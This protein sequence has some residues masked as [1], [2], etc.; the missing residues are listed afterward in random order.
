MEHYDAIVLGTGGIGSAAL[1]HLARSGARVLGIDRFHPPHDRGSS[2]GQTRVIRQAYFEHPDYVPLLLESYR[3]WRE[4]EQLSEQKLFHQIGL[5]QIGPA[6]G[7]VIPG[8]LRAAAAHDLPVCPITAD[9]IT[10]RWPGLRIP[11][12]LV[13]AFEPAAGYLLV[14]DCVQ[15]HLDAARAAGAETLFDVEVESWSAAPSEVRVRISND[16]IA[17]KHLVIAAGAWAGRLL[18]ELN[19]ALSI[20]RKSLFWFATGSNEYLAASFPVFLLELPHG[21]FY[22]FPKLD[23][24]GL[25]FAEHSGG[26]TIEHPLKVN[27]S[28]DTEEQRRLVGVLA[29]YLPDVTDRVTDH[30]TC[31]YTMSPDE[32]FIVGR[33]PEH[34]NVVFAAG[35]SGHGFKFAPVLGRALAD[36]ALHGGTNSPIE[37]LSLARFNN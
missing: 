16:E 6:D 3:E 11:H 25:K 30:M 35:L 29:Q 23:D 4:L 31:L 15:S 19:V 17:A 20:R 34:P 7:I 8:V 14:E 26:Q 33:H 10:R 21:V 18:A 13:G 5:I 12:D 24:R 22:G 1:Y 2:H 27:R 28:I 36:L 9:E 32:N 37:F